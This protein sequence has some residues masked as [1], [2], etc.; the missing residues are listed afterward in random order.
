MDKTEAPQFA[1][2]G[3]PFDDLFYTTKPTLYQTLYVKKF[4][5][6]QI[7]RLISLKI[8]FKF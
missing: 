1:P 4:D 8:F 2:S 7:F 3:R 6:F 5:L